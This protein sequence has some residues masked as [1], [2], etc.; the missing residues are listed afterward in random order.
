MDRNA[1]SLAGQGSVSTVALPKHG[2]MTGIGSSR[3]LVHHRSQALVR[4][5][6]AQSYATGP[7]AT[8]HR[9]F[10]SGYRGSPLGA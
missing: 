6:L 3:Y 9:G 8:A 4:L 5:L 7:P 2:W 1:A 10:V